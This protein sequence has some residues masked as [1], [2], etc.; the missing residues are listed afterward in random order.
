MNLELI[1]F[2][3]NSPSKSS[4]LDMAPLLLI[5]TTPPEM[6]I[7][8]R[9]ISTNKPT[10][11]TTATSPLRESRR[12]RLSDRRRLMMQA[13]LLRPR[14]PPAVMMNQL[15]MRCLILWLM[16]SKADVIR[17]ARGEGM[18]PYDSIQ[19]VISANILCLQ[20][21]TKDGIW[22]IRWG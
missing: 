10:C 18:L 15:M 5:Q 12:E 4:N 11:T 17:K 14:L 21:F 19:I 3:S 8:P 1:E 20:H 9:S 13:M 6:S 7:C 2:H 16:M 22:F